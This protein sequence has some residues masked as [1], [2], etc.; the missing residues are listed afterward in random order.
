MNELNIIALGSLG[1]ESIHFDDVFLVGSRLWG[2][3]T[4]S[5]DYDLLIVADDSIL[6]EVPKSQH[7]KQYDITLLTRS[8]FVAR[9]MAGSFI[10][11]VCCLMGEEESC[12]LRR[13]QLMRHLVPDVSVV[14]NWVAARYGD[15]LEKAKKFWQ[16]GKRKDAFKI[17][18]HMLMAESVIRGLRA[19]LIGTPGHLCSISL[20]MAELQAFVRQG[21]DES[22]WTWLGLEWDVVQALHNRRLRGQVVEFA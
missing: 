21:S 13:A 20:T 7:K 22:D 19:K 18:Q 4:H 3:N 10:E 12:V 5:S 2:T 14:E 1:L 17:L 16:K 8:E 15:D 9:L 11:T 6:A